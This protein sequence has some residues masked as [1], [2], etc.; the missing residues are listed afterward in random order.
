MKLSTRRLIG[1]VLLVALLIATV[2]WVDAG[3]PWTRPGIEVRAASTS[4]ATSV[5]LASSTT[6]I[7][8][9]S[10]AG[11]HCTG[12]RYVLFALNDPY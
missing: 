4:A 2:V 7:S 12:R 9:L 8:P 1:I 11:S 10:N 5:L 6:P 3:R